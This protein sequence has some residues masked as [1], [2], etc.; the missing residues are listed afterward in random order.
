MPDLS[1]YFAIEIGLNSI[2]WGVRFSDEHILKTIPI[3]E[4]IISRIPVSERSAFLVKEALTYIRDH[5]GYELSTECT[6][7]IPYLTCHELA[8]IDSVVEQFGIP[9]VRVKKR[10]SCLACAISKAGFECAKDEFFLLIDY[11]DV[12]CETAIAQISDGVV[13]MISI[14][15]RQINPDTPMSTELLRQDIFKAIDS[16]GIKRIIRTF[17]SDSLPIS[18]RNML[19][20]LFHMESVRMPA[21]SVLQGAMNISGR[22]A[23]IIND[24]LLIDAIDYEIL[25]GQEVVISNGA[26]IP[27]N[28]TIEINYRTSRPDQCIDI[29]IRKNNIFLDQPQHIRLFVNP[30]IDRKQSVQKLSVTSIINGAERISFIVENVQSGEKRKYAWDQIRMKL[31]QP[32]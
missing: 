15:Q 4:A 11:N 24:L 23:G 26:S 31:K 14:I 13:E 22:R 10:I 5:E 29:Y 30:L 8:Q 7:T 9:A 19:K 28:K 32:I 12:S 17:D 3:S 27:T 16:S 6:I 21:D 18:Y 1:S 25:V 20:D 2:R